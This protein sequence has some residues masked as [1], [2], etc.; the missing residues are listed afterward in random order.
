MDAR[1]LE[2]QIIPIE[3]IHFI[4]SGGERGTVYRNAIIRTAKGADTLVAL[5]PL[6]VG[7]TWEET[8]QASGGKLIKE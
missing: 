2:V 8:I 5:L 3:P 7:L 4:T 6:S 1:T